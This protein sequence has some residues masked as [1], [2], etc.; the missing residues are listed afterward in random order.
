MK[1]TKAHIEKSRPIEKIFDS[2]GK[3]KTFALKKNDKSGPLG[4]YFYYIRQRGSNYVVY[5]GERENWKL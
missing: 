3:A 1:R 5:K 2:S 4:R